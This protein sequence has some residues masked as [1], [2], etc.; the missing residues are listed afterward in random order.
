LALDEEA[1]LDG[2][3]LYFQKM[4]TSLYTVCI[5]AGLP[6]KYIYFVIYRYVNLSVYSYSGTSNDYLYMREEVVD[7]SRYRYKI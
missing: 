4:K 1:N 5:F 7:I 6:Y 3:V 2:F